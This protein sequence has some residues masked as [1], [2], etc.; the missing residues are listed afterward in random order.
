MKDFKFFK[1][2]VVKGDLNT[3]LPGDT[4]VT[5]SIAHWMANNVITT[6]LDDR[7]PLV[8][9]YENSVITGRTN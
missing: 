2:E 9:D 1:R 8:V 7:V 5:M 3:P 4:D 6:T